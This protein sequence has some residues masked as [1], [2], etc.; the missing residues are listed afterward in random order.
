MTPLSPEQERLLEQVVAGD[1]APDAPHVRNECDRSPAFARELDAA[2]ALIRRLESVANDAREDIED[3]R[4]ESSVP[5][6][7]AIADTVRE[8]LRKG[9]AG[10]S[11]ARR[12]VL[13]STVAILALAAVLGLAIVFI[14]NDESATSPPAPPHYLGDALQCVAPR[15]NDADFRVFR[16]NGIL[17]KGAWFEVVILAQDGTELIRSHRLDVNEFLLSD[18]QV[19]ALPDEIEWQVLLRDIGGVRSSADAVAAR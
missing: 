7:D 12:S 15:G 18:E 11:T 10:A 6:E 9:R 13:Q 8:R 3:A 4:Q 5:G 14:G 2:I 16:F 19:R 1:V 17:P